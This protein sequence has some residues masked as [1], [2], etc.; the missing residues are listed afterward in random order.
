MSGIHDDSDDFIRDGNI[1]YGRRKERAAIVA[2]LRMMRD[3]HAI[4]VIGT[5]ADAI[6]AGEHLKGE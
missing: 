3:V 1:E 2:W 4:P 5:L 6:E